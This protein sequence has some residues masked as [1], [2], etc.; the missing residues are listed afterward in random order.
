MKRRGIL[1]IPKD[2]YDSDEINKY[3]FG[4]QIKIYDIR[5]K[6]F[7][8]IYKI[9]FVSPFAKEVNEECRAL[10]YNI[11]VHENGFLLKEKDY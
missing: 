8:D 9:Y 4:L 6:P 3:L 1:R 7:D 11:E 5:Y 10:D 2:I